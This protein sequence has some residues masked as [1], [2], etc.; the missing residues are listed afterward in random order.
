MN[1]RGM[2]IEKKEINRK[3]RKEGEKK[4]RIRERQRMN[5]CRKEGIFWLN[6]E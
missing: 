1:N 4:I 5:E 3:R 6:S 2:D